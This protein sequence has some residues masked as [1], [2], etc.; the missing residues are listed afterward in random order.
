MG[1]WKPDL[2]PSESGETKEASFL[3]RV[4]DILSEMHQGILKEIGG[5]QYEN[6]FCWT[7]AGVVGAL[8]PDSTESIKGLNKEKFIELLKQNSIKK[9][10]EVGAGADSM[11]FPLRSTFKAAG[12]EMLG[13]GTDL[14]LWQRNDFNNAQIQ[15]IKKEAGNLKDE[16]LDL[17]LVIAHNV[18]SLGGQ[19]TA[20]RF[21]DD[22]K[23]MI[24]LINSA[25][26]D[27]I[28]QL[29][30][31]PRASVVLF[32]GFD[33]MPLD[34]AIIAKEANILS[35]EKQNTDHGWRFRAHADDPDY[36][37]IYEPYVRDIYKQAPNFVVLQKKIQ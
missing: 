30:D 17:D 32:E 28:H 14:P 21:G 26:V 33:L 2:N 20:G 31:N 18:F 12:C 27:V 24:Q 13:I 15:I 1:E 6:K 5:A 22:S 7:F 19:L 4:H 25:V 3:L 23:K 29:S 34:K 37:D 35:W 11:I 8:A 10:A 16:K 9:V 36:A